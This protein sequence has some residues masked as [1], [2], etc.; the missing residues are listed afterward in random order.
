MK[1]VS[2]A[3][4]SLTVIYFN[5]GNKPYQILVTQTVYSLISCVLFGLNFPSFVIL[6]PDYYSTKS[7][8]T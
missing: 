7:S 1:Y 2:A 4:G 5:I 3:P 8:K 6:L